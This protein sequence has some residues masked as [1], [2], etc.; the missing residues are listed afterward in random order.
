MHIY[1]CARV[2]ICARFTCTVNLLNITNRLSHRWI[3]HWNVHYRKHGR[4]EN[5][6]LCWRSTHWIRNE[7]LNRICFIYRRACERVRRTY[8]TVRWWTMDTRIKSLYSV[9]FF[10]RH[11]GAVNAMEH[12]IRIIHWVAVHRYR[13][14]FSSFF[15]SLSLFS[16]SHTAVVAACYLCYY[17]S[18]QS[19]WAIISSE[20]LRSTQYKMYIVGDRCTLCKQLKYSHEHFNTRTIV[21]Y[22]RFVYIASH[23]K[24]SQPVSQSA[25]LLFDE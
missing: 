6:C 10:V 15:C 17:S 18:M 13:H 24:P 3:C 4:I 11:S 21:M 1:A 20:F 19:I 22:A 25:S 9:F 16:C 23:H 14:D 8:M 12:H 5:E 7:R 2:I